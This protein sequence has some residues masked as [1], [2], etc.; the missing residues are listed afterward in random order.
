MI[1]E[2]IRH[3]LSMAVFYEPGPLWA[4]VIE[5][6]SCGFGI[7]RQCCAGLA[8]SL[9]NFGSPRLEPCEL[10]EQLTRLVHCVE[11]YSSNGELGPILATSGRVLALFA[12]V[13][14]A[15]GTAALTRTDVR[16]TGL[17][18]N[19]SCKNLLHHIYAGAVLL[20]VSAETPD[21]QVASSHVLLRNSRNDIQTFEYTIPVAFHTGWD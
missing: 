6:Q 4:A 13:C 9:M 19:G 7:D 16:E 14:P 10:S 3:R 2:A 17:P 21:Q 1:K 12:G 20:I 5:L 8:E 15:R 11:P 18:L